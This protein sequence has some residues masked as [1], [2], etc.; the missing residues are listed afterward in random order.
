[1]LLLI[2]ECNIPIFVLLLN[3]NL[4]LCRVFESTFL[5]HFVIYCSRSCTGR[6]LKT[7]FSTRLLFFIKS[8]FRGCM[9][10]RTSV[11]PA[12]SL[13]LAIIM[14]SGH[15]IHRVRD[16]ILRGLAEA[17]IPENPFPELANSLGILQFIWTT[18]R[19]LVWRT[20]CVQLAAVK[21][22]IIFLWTK[23]HLLGT[24]NW[25][26]LKATLYQ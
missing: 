26:V 19:H 9:H 14:S 20:E 24:L 1:M 10:Q 11:K 21:Y 18:M 8:D 15:E 3:W 25:W 17:R 13:I 4:I 6:Y 12:G 16:R 22:Q 5:G 23:F 7:I 2:L